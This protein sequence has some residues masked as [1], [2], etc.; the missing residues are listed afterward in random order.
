M[1]AVCVGI[2]NKLSKLEHDIKTKLESLKA[3]R[4]ELIRTLRQKYQ[5]EV[6]LHQPRMWTPKSKK[7]NIIHSPTP[8]KVKQLFVPSCQA[9]LTGPTTISTSQK[10]CS[11]KNPEQ[12]EKKEKRAKIQ[13]FYPSK[14]KVVFRGKKESVKSKVIP[15]GVY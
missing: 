5:G 3:D 12:E 1:F 10:S 9:D 6:S 13:L 14:I 11:K 4:L 15:A 2:L 7:H 8:R